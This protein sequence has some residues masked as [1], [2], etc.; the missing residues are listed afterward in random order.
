LRSLQLLQ[1]NPK[2]TLKI[3]M[4]WTGATE[5]DALRSL[6]LAKPGFSKNGLLTD[7]DLSIERGFIQQQTK[8]TTVPVSLAHDM[9]LL[10]EVQR[11]LGI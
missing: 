2:D 10:K 3:L 7:E 4:N 5:K 9:T 1:S 11:E 8:K 6:E